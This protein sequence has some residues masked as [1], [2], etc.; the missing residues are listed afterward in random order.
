MKAVKMEEQKEFDLF[1]TKWTIEYLD[2]IKDEKD[3]YLYG[4]T[5]PVKKHIRIARTMRGVALRE[6]E[7][8]VTLYHELFHAVFS[9]GYY[10]NPN[11][12][13]PMV[14]WCAKCLRTLV[15]QKVI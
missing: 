4:D 11:E 7:L 9:E 3:C 6:S 8:N 12:D 1:G 13:E 14:E 2:E 10:F 15:D 5:D